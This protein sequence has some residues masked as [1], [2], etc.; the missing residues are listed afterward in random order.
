MDFNV[1]LEHLDELKVAMDLV[2][3]ERGVNKGIHHVQMHYSLRR[4]ANQ[5]NGAE[6]FQRATKAAVRGSKNTKPV[7]PLQ[8]DILFALFDLDGIPNTEYQPNAGS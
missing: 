3:Q 4:K 6:Q 8:I 2:M 5:L 1:F 7:T